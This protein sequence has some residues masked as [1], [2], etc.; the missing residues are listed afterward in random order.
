MT[1][2]H[3]IAIAPEKVQPDSKK[4]HPST[5]YFATKSGKKQENVT[6]QLEDV[7]QSPPTAA[8]APVAVASKELSSRQ[9]EFTNAPRPR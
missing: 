6:W 4:I 3:V 9:A 7:I 8:R 5:I 1:G 2:T